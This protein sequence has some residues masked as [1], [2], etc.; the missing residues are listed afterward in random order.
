MLPA[1]LDEIY[2]GLPLAHPAAPTTT[3]SR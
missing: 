2:V 3:K 1:I